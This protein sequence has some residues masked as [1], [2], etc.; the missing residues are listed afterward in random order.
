[1]SASLSA[2]RVL[3]PCTSA[4]ILSCMRRRARMLLAGLLLPCGPARWQPLPSHLV[5]VSFQAMLPHLHACLCHAP[6]NSPALVPSDLTNIKSKPTCS[7]YTHAPCSTRLHGGRAHL[8]LIRALS[9][10]V[11]AALTF[12]GLVGTVLSDLLW[13][14]VRCMSRERAVC[15][16]CCCV[17]RGLV[18]GLGYVLYSH[19]QRQLQ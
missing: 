18:L 8:E 14:Q 10:R 17:N 15:S 1:M 13:A 5:R 19:S 4:S 9:P 7:D 3:L 16:V 6:H 11:T 2:T 12:N